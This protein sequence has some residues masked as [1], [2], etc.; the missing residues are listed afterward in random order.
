M[1]MDDDFYD[2]DSGNES[3]D[4][5]CLDFESDGEG[6]A[7]RVDKE[8]EESAFEVLSIEEVSQHMLECIDEF[9]SVAE[10]RVLAVFSG[11]YSFILKCI[12]DV[13]I[14]LIRK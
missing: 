2:G 13:N 12:P 1:D 9:T 7:N 5:D 10:V 11:C 3:S 4:L 6:S 14:V 8:S